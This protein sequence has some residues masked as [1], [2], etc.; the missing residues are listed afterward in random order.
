MQAIKTFTRKIRTPQNWQRDPANV[1]TPNVQFWARGV[2]V[3]VITLIAARERIQNGTAFV[4]NDQAIG[5][6]SNGQYDS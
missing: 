5:L 2:M 3:G 4:I 6:L 1:K